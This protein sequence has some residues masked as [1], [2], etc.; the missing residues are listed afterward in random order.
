MDYIKY[1]KYKKYKSKYKTLIGG[2]DNNTR[3][4][5]ILLSYETMDDP[6]E[7]ITQMPSLYQFSEDQ[8]QNEFYIYVA[9]QLLNN[10]IN[11]SNVNSIIRYFTTLEEDNIRSQCSVSLYYKNGNWLVTRTIKKRAIKTDLNNMWF[12]SIL[13]SSKIDRILMPKYLFETLVRL[14]LIKKNKIWNS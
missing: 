1:K 10:L 8:Q 3:Y 12:V 6:F 7:V 5:L 13:Q 11:K 2:V 9:T 4:R 14:R